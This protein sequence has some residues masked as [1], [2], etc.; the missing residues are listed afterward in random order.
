[1][2]NKTKIQHSKTTAVYKHQFNRSKDHLKGKK[3]PCS[4]MA[5]KVFHQILDHQKSN[6]QQK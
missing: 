4:K 2:M 6:K 3:R 5:V 1:M